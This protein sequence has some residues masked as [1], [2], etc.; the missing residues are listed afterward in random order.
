MQ[1][2]AHQSLD[3]FV[4]AQKF[5]EIYSD[6]IT[7]SQLEWALRHREE[8]GLAPAVKKIGRSLIIH[9]PTFTKWL[10]DGGNKA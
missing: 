10:M 6:L 2:T 1:R 7:R 9:V 3:E 5:P 8:N 4:P